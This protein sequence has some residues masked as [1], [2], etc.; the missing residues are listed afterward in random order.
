MARV[1]LHCDCNS[2]YA[3]VEL[4]SRP[5]LKDK[6]VAVCGNPELRHG[7]ILAK[8]EAA[9]AYNIKTAE[10]VY[11]ALQK[12]KNL[13]LLAPHH[14]LY[15]HYSEILNNIYAQYTDLVEPFGID[16]SWLDITGSMHLFGKSG[17]D[18]AALIKERVK[19]ET[20]LTVS[21]GVSF[22][23]VFAKLGSD[24]KKPDAITVFDENNYKDRVWPLDA[25]NLLYVGKATYN[26][27]LNMGIKT[28]GELAKAPVEHLESS[29]GK[30]G[31]E[32]NLYALGKDSSPVRAYN[33]KEQI[34]SVGNGLTFS[35]NL[36]G[37]DDLRAGIMSLCDEVASRLRRMGLF[38]TCV[39]VHIKNTELKSISRQKQLQAPTCLAK[40]LS[41]EALELVCA[42]W[43]L[44]RPVRMLTITALGLTEDGDLKQAS[45]FDEQEEILSSAKRENL[46]RSLD[47]IR[48]K[49]GKRSVATG[50]NVK[51][52]IGIG[53]ISMKKE[54][55][56]LTKQKDEE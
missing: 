55:S 42:N 12:C 53:S 20:G 11:S 31:V 54:H 10:T 4:L 1:I 43:D 33:E 22:N 5:E 36:L 26:T 17:E 30:Q 44:K 8:N 46:E 47:L 3:S 16:E 35:R 15:T 50:R 23:K 52:D 13:V 41:R 9:K 18:V 27:L 38:A 49:Y 51:N 48:K 7:I 2:F 28:I 45:F 24:Y 29:L 34:K 19:R 40:D 14:N 39:Q 32:L 37:Y 21:I 6:P 56:N 25:Q